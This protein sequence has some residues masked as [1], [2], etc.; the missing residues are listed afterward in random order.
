M[1]TAFIPAYNSQ[2][3]IRQVIQAVKNQSI[4]PER[5]VVIDSGSVDN[6]KNIVRAEGV[7]FYSPQD[8]GFD[9]L[10][11][12]RA[13]NR[14]LDLIDTPYL[15]SV[16]SDVVI[17]KDYIKKL[18]PILDDNEEIAGIAGK[19]IELN[20]I[21]L[22]DRARAVIEM[23]DLLLPL[24]QQQAHFQDF[25]LGS[26]NIY[27]VDSLQKISYHP[28]EDD[29]TTNYE[30]VD[31]G[32]KLRGI[33]YKLFF[34]P[35]V[36]TYH[37]QQDDLYSF[38]NRAYRYRVFKWKLRGA[39]EN[40]EI[41]AGKTEHNINYTKMGFEIAI[42]KRRYY[43]LY[44]YFLIGFY[45][46]LKDAEFFRK[47]NRNDVAAKIRALFFEYLNMI[48]NQE[49]QN[50]ILNDL[51]YLVDLSAETHT[52]KSLSAIEDWFSSL[53]SLTNLKSLFMI[54]NDDYIASM[55]LL[56]RKRIDLERTLK[57]F[58]SKKVLLLNTTDNQDALDNYHT[59][60]STFTQDND[61]MNHYLVLQNKGISSW[62]IDAAYE[63]YNDDEIYYEI[64]GYKP[65]KIYLQGELNCDLKMKIKE[66]L[67]ATEIIELTI[68]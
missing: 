20:R 7:E 22:P 9:F 28:F 40:L 52:I 4:Q 41:Y 26:N 66:S 55:L 1:I 29:L 13:R 68:V 18:L 56:S 49:L 37:L 24:N 57:I 39:F 19:Q 6:T 27:R 34:T 3:T 42:K 15:L 16:D 35:E 23:R 5:I 10:G 46:F 44:P 2:R 53:V 12:G 48:K 64:V 59:I 43:L 11:L 36:L 21:Y 63:L 25:L 54:D 61:F 60:Y 51:K 8:F 58:G 32:S 65:E 47:A 50:F 62:I 45:F 30:D 31:I 17:E 14:I 67:P 33:G 38:V